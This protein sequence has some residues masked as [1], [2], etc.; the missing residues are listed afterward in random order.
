MRPADTAI[1]PASIDAR[2]LLDAVR[3]AAAP[4]PLLL[5]PRAAWTFLGVSKSAFYR[6]VAAGDLPAAVNVPGA[7]PRWRRAD[8]ERWA[9]RLKPRRG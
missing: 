5:E 4:P 8:L 9:E 6:L 3:H 1:T 7:G 2:M